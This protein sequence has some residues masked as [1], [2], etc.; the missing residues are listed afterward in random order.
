MSSRRPALAAFVSLGA[1]LGSCAGSTVRRADPPEREY[2]A[3]VT[4][5]KWRTAI[6]EHGLFEPRPE[7][8]ATGTVVGDRL[9]IGSRA[10]RAVALALSDGQQLWSTEVTGSID[11]EARYDETHRQAY[12][13]T[14]D[15]YIYAIDPQDGKIRWTYRARG[16]VE[17]RPELGGDSVFFSTAGDRVL[18]LDPRTGKPLWQY[19]RDPPDG[20]TIHGHAGPRLAGGVVYA[21]FADGFMVA[22]NAGTGDVMWA[23]SL[24]AASEQY[25][26]VDAT[27][28]LLGE[29]LVLAA[30]YSGGL[31]ALTAGNGELRWR[32]NVEGASSVQ[33]IGKRLYFAAP[34]DGLTALTDKGDVLWRQGL[35][36]AGDLTPP[37]AVGRALV[38]TGSRA[39]MFVVDRETGKLLELF[40][41]G[42]G[43]CGTAAVS[44]D[45]QTLYVL[46]NSGSVYAL[47]FEQ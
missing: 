32:L 24:A 6:H 8:C 36:D 38:F 1:L 19:E 3:G 35:A 17:R 41:P 7:E 13:G 15:G 37:F 16:A 29:E 27:P 9:L 42:R 14:D 34:R 25:V 22:L 39:G 26:D 47:G 11:S 46:A 18:S 31:Y 12:F 45:Q 20:F 28:A 5:V 2:P 43:M 21:G 4:R 10:G 40:N 30:S 33:V 23:R 44:P